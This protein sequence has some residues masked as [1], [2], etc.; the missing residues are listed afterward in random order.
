M[1]LDEKYWQERWSNHD[2]P[3]DMGGPSPALTTYCDQ[4]EDDSLGILIPGAGSGYEADWLWE[5]GF[6]NVHV[7]D[8]SGEALARLEDRMPSFPKRQLIEGDFFQHEGSYDLILEQT[9]FCALDPS[10]RPAYAL[11]MFSLLKEGGTLA[12][13][14]FDMPLEGGPPFGGRADDYRKL[15]EPLFEVKTMAPCHNSIKP[16]EGRELFFILKKR[17]LGA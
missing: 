4:L 11:K 13:L 14:L 10:L 1:P 12:G 17:M 5:H 16:R 3:W 6:R 2:T 15:F 9:F 7:L 8:F